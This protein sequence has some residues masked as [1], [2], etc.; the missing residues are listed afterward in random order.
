[1][2]CFAD[3]WG[4]NARLRIHLTEGGVLRIFSNNYTMSVLARSY[5]LLNSIAKLEDTWAMATARAAHSHDSIYLQCLF[6]L[7]HILWD[8]L[9]NVGHLH[10]LLQ[11]RPQEIQ[12]TRARVASQPV[13]HSHHQVVTQSYETTAEE[14]TPRTCFI[15]PSLT[16]FYYAYKWKVHTYF[17]L[18]ETYIVVHM[19]WGKNY[20]RWYTLWVFGSAVSLL[21]APCSS[22]SPCD[23][24]EQAPPSLYFLLLPKSIE[25][26]L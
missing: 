18:W 9:D 24:A 1:M 5:I 22:S 13:Q 25:S 19:Q 4:R 12:E 8:V 14:Q 6:Q 26:P 3:L 17:L 15:A 20:T 23:Q 16:F 2:G 21:L 10:R 11:L 7:L